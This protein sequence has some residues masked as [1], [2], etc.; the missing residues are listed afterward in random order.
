MTTQIINNIEINIS[1]KQLEDFL[2]FGKNLE[3]YLGLKFIARQVSIPPAGIIDILAYNKQSKCFV[4][5][6]L[7]KDLLDTSA[8]I[9]GM[10]YLKYYQDVRKLNDFKNYFKKEFGE[11]KNRKRSFS[12]LLIG[13][14]LDN[15][16]IKIIDYLDEQELQDNKIYYKLF[17]LNILSGIDFNFYNQNQENYNDA[18]MEQMHLLDI[19]A[20]NKS[21]KLSVRS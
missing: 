6:E 20:F 19:D 5:I 21:L 10:A 3:K 12:L 13:K 4:I 14:N 15:N 9:Q 8:L 16:L 18:L 7:K 2:C 1:E 17:G 11:T